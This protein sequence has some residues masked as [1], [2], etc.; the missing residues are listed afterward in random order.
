[1]L[2]CREHVQEHRIRNSAVQ[3]LERGETAVHVRVAAAGR[4]VAFDGGI[5]P[6]IFQHVLQKPACAFHARQGAVGCETF[7]F[8]VH[9]SVLGH[10]PLQ[11]DDHP[12]MQERVE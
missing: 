12:V 4:R 1:M 8:R 11:R 5:I 3:G 7:E 6:G 2:P 10:G 9:V